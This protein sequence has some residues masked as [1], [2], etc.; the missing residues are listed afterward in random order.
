MQ[1]A[2]L[3]CPECGKLMTL[4]NSRFGPFYG[5]SD[6]P[7][8]RATHGAHPDGR[9]LGT[10]GDRE[11][12]QARIA[13]HAVFDKLWQG[14]GAPV[15]RGHAYRVVQIVMAMTGKQAHIGLFDKSQCEQLIAA[16]SCSQTIAAAIEQVKVERSKP[17]SNTKTKKRKYWQRMHGKSKSK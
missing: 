9:P 15:K 7:R 2:T 13:A 5:C 3:P 10:P 1:S 14:D 17:E 6:F 16:L 4:R 11:T 12:K 8:C